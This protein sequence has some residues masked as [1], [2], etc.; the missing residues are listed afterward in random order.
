MV[1]GA[2][3]LSEIEL[4]VDRTGGLGSAFMETS[5]NNK[6]QTPFG[7]F[8]LIIDF[9]T[10]LL[11]YFLLLLGLLSLSVFVLQQNYGFSVIFT[12]IYEYVLFLF[13]CC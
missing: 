12:T 3:V 4:S 13:R 9:C 6:L 11:K 8:L 10:V 7:S 1:D 2:Q 5:D